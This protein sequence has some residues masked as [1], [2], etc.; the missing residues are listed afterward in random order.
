MSLGAYEGG[1]Q[2]A[3]IRVLVY[4]SH[5]FVSMAAMTKVFWVYLSNSG[6]GVLV[7]G[8]HCD[9]SQ[10]KGGGKGSETCGVE[11]SQISTIFKRVS[12]V[13]HDFPIQLILEAKLGDDHFDLSRADCCNRKF[14]TLFYLQKRLANSSSLK[15]IE[16]AGLTARFLRKYVSICLVG[17][18]VHEWGSISPPRTETS[19]DPSVKVRVATAKRLSPTGALY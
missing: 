9:V 19:L 8:R 15:K 13:A 4:P 3:T 12:V 2:P 5:V 6:W 10:E 16:S 11:L 1:K 14:M 17:L 18:A 7:R